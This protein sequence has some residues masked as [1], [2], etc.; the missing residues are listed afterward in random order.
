VFLSAIALTGQAQSPSGRVS[1]HGRVV[2]AETGAP[3][4]NARVQPT[5]AT[6]AVPP[7]FTDADGRFAISVAVDSPSLS[8]TKPGYL[9][10]IVAMPRADGDVDVRMPKAGAISGRI[11]DTLGD[12][13]IGMTVTAEVPDATESGRKAGRRLTSWCL[14]AGP[15]TS[16]GAPDPESSLARCRHRTRPA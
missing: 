14:H 16:S 15:S 3:L 12:P 9:P 11:T 5:T 7:A 10:T 8:V 2:A 6:Q 13:L 4:R 1:L